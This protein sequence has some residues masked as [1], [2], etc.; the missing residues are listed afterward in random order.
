MSRNEQV[1]S[2]KQQEKMTL[3]ME[4]EIILFLRRLTTQLQRAIPRLCSIIE[5][6][7]NCQRY[8]IISM[9][10]EMEL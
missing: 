5:S 6:W 8:T 9:I 2:S 4:M 10:M 1:K 7:I 3:E